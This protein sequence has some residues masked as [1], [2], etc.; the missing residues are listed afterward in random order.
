MVCV[1]LIYKA[2]FLVLLAFTFVALAA[3]KKTGPQDPGTGLDGWMILLGSSLHSVLVS[4]W[5]LVRSRENK[6]RSLWRR[7]TRGVCKC[8]SEGKR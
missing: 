6:P 8:S 4:S 2:G 1:C 7:W 3:G 5:C